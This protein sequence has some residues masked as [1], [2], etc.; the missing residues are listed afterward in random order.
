[1][2]HVAFRR[3]SREDRL[4][5]A[6]QAAEMLRRGVSLLIFA[7]GTFVPAPGV[8]AFQLGAFQAA[9]DAQVPVVPVSLRGVREMLR[10]LTW[11]P[12]PSRVSIT[13]SPAI[14]PQGNGWHEVIRLRDETRAAVA[15][16]SGEHIL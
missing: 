10:D 14:C 7:E 16:H 9:V 3:D 5:Q 15:A 4:R 6:N 12:R 11:L 13:V 1:M 8:R 2:G